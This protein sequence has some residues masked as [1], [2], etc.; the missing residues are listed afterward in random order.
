MALIMR[1]VDWLVMSSTLCGVSHQELQPLSL[2]GITPRSNAG[3]F[4]YTFIALC[5]LSTR[6]NP[7]WVGG[8]RDS[9][10]IPHHDVHSAVLT[11]VTTTTSTSTVTFATMPAYIPSKYRLLLDVISFILSPKSCFFTLMNDISNA[12]PDVY[13]RWSHNGGQAQYH[14]LHTV[15]YQQF[16]HQYDAELSAYLHTA[17]HTTITEFEKLVATAMKHS[18]HAGEGVAT[19]VGMLK[20]VTEFELWVELMRSSAKR[21]YLQSIMRGYHLQMLEVSNK[22]GSWVKGAKDLGAVQ[23]VAASAQ[24]QQQFNASTNG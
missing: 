15:H 2:A 16:M 1:I 8:N 9:A 13:E 12:H 6:K 24:L 20:Q 3:F 4:N 17:H 10:S 23:K 21:Q 14:I 5:R 7:P 11:T 19:F 22:R 18:G